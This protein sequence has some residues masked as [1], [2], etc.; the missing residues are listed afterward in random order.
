MQVQSIY[1]LFVLF[2]LA[3]INRRDRIINARHGR[4]FAHI[5]IRIIALPVSCY[6]NQPAPLES[7]HLIKAGTCN[8]GQTQR[9]RPRA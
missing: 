1:L 6:S 9:K 7:Q 5:I 3:Q 2:L 4:D 8:P